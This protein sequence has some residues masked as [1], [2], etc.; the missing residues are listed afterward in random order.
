MATTIKYTLGK[1]ERLK[2]RKKIEEL[3][4]TGKSFSLFPFRVVY[5]YFEAPVAGEQL[6]VGFSV[7]TRNFK[8]AVDRNRIK[9]LMK[10]S[11]RLQKHTLQQVLSS[12]S[13][14]INIFFIFTDNKVPDYNLVFEKMTAVIKRLH[15][16]VNENT[17]ANT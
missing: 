2:S 14:T 11:Y 9:R 16:I 1:T 6:Q 17:A 13:K 4:K 3:F 8:K 5:L 7:S 12:T 15:K 10:E